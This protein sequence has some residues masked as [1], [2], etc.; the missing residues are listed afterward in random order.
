VIC[1]KGNITEENIRTIEIRRDID[2]KHVF[3]ILKRIEKKEILQQV[4]YLEQNHL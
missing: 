3:I 4:S 2:L 1:G